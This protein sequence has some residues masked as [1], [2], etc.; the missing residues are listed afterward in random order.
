MGMVHVD[1]L[2]DGMVLAEDARDITFR[3]LLAKGQRITA[4]HIR[5]FKI[6]GVS[7]AMVEGDCGNAE[8][9]EPSID[10]ERIEEVRAK[11]KVIFSTDKNNF[12]WYTFKKPDGSVFDSFRRVKTRAEA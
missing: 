7:Q 10:P 2:K 4:R 9:T 1:N 11:T 3:L 12:E 6:W 8:T 5:I